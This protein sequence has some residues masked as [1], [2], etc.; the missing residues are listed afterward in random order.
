MSVLNQKLNLSGDNFHDLGL[1]PMEVIN[2]CSDLV[3]NIND[4]T[5]RRFKRL[6]FNL[7]KKAH[8]KKTNNAIQNETYNFYFENYSYDESIY[9]NGFSHKKQAQ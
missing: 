2:L 1:G 7:L 4:N 5:N 6:H 9:T 3:Y 8:S